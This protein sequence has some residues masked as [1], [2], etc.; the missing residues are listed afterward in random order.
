ML[1]ERREKK[2]YCVR[3][4]RAGLMEDIAFVLNPEKG[5]GFSWTEVERKCRLE[6]HYQQQPPKRSLK[7]ILVGSPPPPSPNFTDKKLNY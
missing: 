4:I 6:P 5:V 7:I 1:K 2:K 3:R